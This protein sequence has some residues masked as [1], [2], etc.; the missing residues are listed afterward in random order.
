MKTIPRT[1][2]TPSFSLLKIKR[3]L[4]LIFS[5]AALTW[6]SSPAQSQTITSVVPKNGQVTINWTGASGPVQVQKT[7]KLLA[8]TDPTTGAVSTA[9]P[10]TITVTDPRPAATTT[11]W[12]Q[13]T[14]VTA[15]PSSTSASMVFLAN[16]GVAQ[17]QHV[18]PVTKSGATSA[19][20]PIIV[21]D[22]QLAAAA[23]T[24]FLAN[25][26]FELLQQHMDSVKS[27]LATTAPQ[28]ITMPNHLPATDTT[29]ASLASQSFALL[30]QYLAGKS[31]GVDPGQI[32]AAVSKAAGWGQEALLTKP[33]C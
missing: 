8:A 5:V 17:Q 29:M 14:T 24:G 20:Q 16:Q 27:T 21:M 30:N 19:P 9:S 25:R 4:S 13:T 28:A 2:T 23:S 18:D 1:I 7:L 31:G 10:Q 33:H 3:I 11:T 6:L 26:G 32:V 15:P 12:P 22:H